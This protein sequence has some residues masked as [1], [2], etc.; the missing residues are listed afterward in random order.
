M[1]HFTFLLGA[2]ATM[3]CIFALIAPA[4]G[5][6]DGQPAPYVTEIPN[7]YRDFRWISSAH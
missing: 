5:H 3:A 2:V 6:A 7:G 1:K 4:P